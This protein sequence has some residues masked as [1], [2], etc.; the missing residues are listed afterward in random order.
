[1]IKSIFHVCLTVN[2]KER[3][4][5]ET[6]D[7]KL[8]KAKDSEIEM[9]ESLLVESDRLVKSGALELPAGLKLET[10]EPFL[11]ELF[12]SFASNKAGMKRAL[13]GGVYHEPDA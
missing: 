2:G 13:K 11:E 9:A 3:V 4:V 1:M 10:I 12:L 6:E 8:A 7:E 5:L